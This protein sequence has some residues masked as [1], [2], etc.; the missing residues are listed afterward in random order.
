MAEAYQFAMEPHDAEWYLVDHD[1]LF[2]SADYLRAWYLEAQLFDRLVDQFGRRWWTRHEAGDYLRTLWAEGQKF[3]AL[4]L[5][6]AIGD[7]D[8]DPA[9]LLG[10]LARR[11]SFSSPEGSGPP[12]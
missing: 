12:P 5:A 11:L 8:I 6:R 2:Y 9:P 10:R 3:N 4:D 7:P 1:D